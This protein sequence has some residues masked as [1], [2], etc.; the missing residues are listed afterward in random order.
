MSFDHQWRWR[1]R[2]PHRFG[3][4]CAIIVQGGRMNSVLIQWPDGTRNVTS[5]WA[6]RKA[7]P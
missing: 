7:K 1:A 6:V 4:R 2:L 3:Q 5:R